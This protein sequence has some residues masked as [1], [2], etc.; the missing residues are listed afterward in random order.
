MSGRAVRMWAMA[1]FCGAA[2]ATQAQESD[3]DDRAAAEETIKS[4]QWQRGPGTASIGAWADLALK[5]DHVFAGGDDTRKL[6]KLMGNLVSGDEEGYVAPSSSEEDWFAV[7]EFD[8]CGYVRDNEK[9]SLDADA[10]LESIREGAV[11]ANKERAKMGYEEMFVEGW[12]IPPH[13]NDQTHNLEW[14][15]NYRTKGNQPVVNHNVRI[16][17]RE[18]VMRVTLVVEPQ[19]LQSSL[20][21]FYDCMKGFSYKKGRRYAEFVQGDKVAA[22]GLSALVLGGAAAAAVKSGLLQK[23]WKPIV[24]GFAALATFFKKLFRRRAS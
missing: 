4:I 1:V 15:V 8:A 14:A 17:G 19:K 2:P 22:Y 23:L 20:P 10:L 6:M 11:R 21:P 12:A 18:G 13:Y 5:E 16:L 7:F 9:A 24:L 3:G